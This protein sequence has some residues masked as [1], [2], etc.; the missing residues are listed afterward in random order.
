MAAATIGYSEATAVADRVQA[1]QN[2]RGGPPGALA[3]SEMSEPRQPSRGMRRLRLL[4][5]SGQGGRACHGH[6]LWSVAPRLDGR[7]KKGPANAGEALPGLERS[8]L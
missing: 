6:Y 8:E 7:L 5:K 1:R 2:A 4:R 3:R